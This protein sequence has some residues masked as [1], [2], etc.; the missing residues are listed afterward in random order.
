MSERKDEEEKKRTENFTE[1]AKLIPFYPNLTDPG[2][3]T[4]SRGKR[5][6]TIMP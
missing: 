3:P 5:N 6:S 1:I 2:L 4:T